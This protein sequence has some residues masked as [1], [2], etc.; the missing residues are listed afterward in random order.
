MAAGSRLGVESHGTSRG[1]HPRPTLKNL[2]KSNRLATAEVKTQ[3]P[4]NSNS[5]P[6]A[7]TKF[8]F[9]GP[10]PRRTAHA[11]NPTRFPHQPHHQTQKL[12][13]MHPPNSKS[14]SSSSARRFLAWWWWCAP[15]ALSPEPNTGISS[16]SNP[17]GGPS[18]RNGTS[19]VAL[20]ASSSSCSRHS[21]G[22]ARLSVTP[23]E[24]TTGTSPPQCLGRVQQLLQ[25]ARR[26]GSAAA[27]EPLLE[28]QQ[29]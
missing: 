25:Q 8:K 21:A 24:R 14:G 26:G 1:P 3:H 10:S 4:P 15:P 17:S 2:K 9:G 23:K 6:H 12:K 29:N 22:A 16:N 5:N 27:S 28:A 18:S 20:A 11:R 13:S 19:R 7:P